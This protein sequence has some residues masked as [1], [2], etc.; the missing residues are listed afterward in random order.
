MTAV[1]AA[2]PLEARLHQFV[3]ELRECGVPV[4]LSERID[5]M[6]AVE[7][8]ELGSPHGLHTVLSATLVKNAE[9]RG[10]FD[11]VF[12]LFF[13]VPSSG[14]VADE[15]VEVPA[16][17]LDLDH[18]LR[19][20]LR[21]GSPA[22]TR[23]L[24][25]QAVARFVD[26]EPGR[27][28]A[29]V[30][31]ESRTVKGIQLDQVSAEMAGELAASGSGEG[32]SGDGGGGSSGA[33][34]RLGRSLQRDSVT[35]RAEAV[36]LQI[37]EVIRQMLVADR[38]A[39]AVAKTLRVPLPTEIV[40]TSA[41]P[42]QLA[43]IERVMR[44]LQR[45]LAT[46]MMRKRRHRAGPPDVRA[47]VRASM[48]TGGVP[49]RIVH[50]RPTPTKAQLFVLADMSGSVATFAAFTVTLV[51]GMAQLFSR[52]KTYA[53]VENTV[54]VTDV[55]R[56]TNNPV[57]VA[58]ALN[59]IEGVE[60][61]NFLNASTDYGRALRQFWEAVGPQLGRRSTVLIFGDARGNYRAAEEATLARI[62]DK[63]GALY[64][65][66]PERASYWGTGDSLMNVYASHCTEAISCRTLSDL[67]RFV[68]TLD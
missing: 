22:L 65:L 51:S 25:E 64:W 28:V 42:E 11:E 5:A 52:L 61:M 58:E 38:G 56:A 15:I 39:E 67:R 66:N 3:D 27:R 23:L 63:A 55:F 46:A 49:V 45:K 19:T 35:E 31:Y 17:P 21:D 2:R 14:A 62:A 43:E 34:S 29:G 24:A 59:R 16:A 68:A 44:D 7:G 8:V 41:N 9:H 40:I 60:G 10:V 30:F 32:G 48:A 36:R 47:T 50:R 54:E 18:A 12:R 1:A 4:S 37:R 26:F 33:G 6:R 53:F 20:V 13:R 57:H